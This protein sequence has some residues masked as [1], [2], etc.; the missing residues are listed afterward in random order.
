MVRLDPRRAGTEVLV[1]IAALIV[2]L[3]LT[4]CAE[5]RQAAID[6]KRTLVRE[7]TEVRQELLPDGKV[8]Q[9]TT[10]TKTV[11]RETSATDEQSR[12]ETEAPKVLSDFGAVAKDV[13]KGAASAAMGPAAGA[14]VDWLWQTVAGVGLAGS[15]AGVGMVMRERKTRRQMVQAQDDYAAD[16][17]AAETDAEVAAIKQKHA[18]RQKALGIHDKLTRERHGV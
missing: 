7:T 10:K 18:A 2:C 14:A 17:E 3:V 6:A 8:I 15:T 5:N 13:V 4:G 1:R 12:I 16:I 11:E 9:L